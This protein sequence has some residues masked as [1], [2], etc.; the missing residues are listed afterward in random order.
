MAKK[1]EEGNYVMSGNFKINLL[2]GFS[3]LTDLDLQEAVILIMST[4]WP[5]F[6]QIYQTNSSSRTLEL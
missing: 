6:Q 3:E 2:L 4:W 5:H 1:N